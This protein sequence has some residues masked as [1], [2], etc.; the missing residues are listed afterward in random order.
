MHASCLGIGPSTGLRASF[1]AVLA[2]KARPE[3]RAV[4]ARARYLKNTTQKTAKFA[5]FKFEVVTTKIA[6][7]S[8]QISNPK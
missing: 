5:Y 6:W 8:H 1:R 7:Q 2:Q 4:P 3:W